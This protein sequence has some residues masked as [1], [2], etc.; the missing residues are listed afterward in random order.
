MAYEVKP[1]YQPDLSQLLMQG[2]G[3]YRQ[4]KGMQQQEA[5]QQ[6]Q[7]EASE[8]DREMREQEFQ[9]RKG[10]YEQKQ[11]DKYSKEFAF[12]RANT[13]KQM[14]GKTPEEKVSILEARISGLKEQGKDPS[15][16]QRLLDMYKTGIQ[17][18]ANLETAQDRRQSDIAYEQSTQLKAADERI[19]EAY[20]TGIN[21]GDIKPD[22]VK[23][24]NI[25]AIVQSYNFAYSPQ[26]QDNPAAQALRK[27]YDLEGVPKGIR[28]ETDK[29]GNFTF[30]SGRG[31][32][33]SQI[34]K[35]TKGNLEKDIADNMTVIAGLENSLSLMNKDMLTY[36]GNLKTVAFPALEK[37]GFKLSPEDKKFMSDVTKFRASSFEDLSKYMNAISGAAIN[38]E[39]AK[40]LKNVLANPDDSPTQYVAKARTIIDKLKKRNRIYNDL[41]REGYKPRGSDTIG[42]VDRRLSSGSDGSTEGRMEDLL[43]KKIA[44]EKIFLIMRAEGYQ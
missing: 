24:D 44:K 33:G 40:R 8:R 6:S 10:E 4:V 28:V 20:Q 13:A 37:A 22:A 11:E 43:K 23:K 21:R 38:A 19:E 2:L 14:R 7:L 3:A 9:M 27:K 18:K 32:T 34:N 41:I 30:V 16:T 39:E 5:M 15:S 36:K 12:E 1:V 26:N 42:E 29:D 35:A 17:G 25:P 31:V